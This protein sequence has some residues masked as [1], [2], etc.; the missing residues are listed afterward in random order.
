VGRVEQQILDR[1]EGSI[2][3]SE[4]LRM[5]HEF[6]ASEACVFEAIR[7]L[8]RKRLVLIET[9]KVSATHQKV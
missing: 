3:G 1:L 9:G 8:L 4:L 7:S 2:A 5:G 6:D